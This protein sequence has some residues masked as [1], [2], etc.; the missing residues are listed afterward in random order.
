MEAHTIRK[1]TTLLSTILMLGLSA[2]GVQANT[3]RCDRELISR[4]DSQ[5]EVLASCGKPVF[6]TQKTIYRS[7]IP[8]RRF[9]S[10]RANDEYLVDITNQE[11]L[12]HQRSVVEVP[13]EVWTY[14]FGPRTFMREVTFTEGRVTSIRTLGYGK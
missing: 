1:I 7:G 11:L 8:Y 13:V 5:G 6:A 4:G 14:N 3:M 2:T 12:V 10:F 9:S